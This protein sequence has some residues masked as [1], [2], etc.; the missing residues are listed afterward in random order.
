[1]NNITPF[2]ISQTFDLNA[3][4]LSQILFDQRH[5]PI[6]ATQVK[7]VGFVDPVFMDTGE[8]RDDIDGASVRTDAP[9]DSPAVDFVSQ[10]SHRN[11]FGNGEIPRKFA[12]RCGDAL[13]FAVKI[14]KKTVPTSIVKQALLERAKL[15]EKETGFAP[16]RAWRREQKEEVTKDL[17]PKCFPSSSLIISYLD[18]RNKFLVIGSS[19]I[20]A[21]EEILKMILK[22][23]PGLA[24]SYLKT[25]QNV[26]NLMSSWV[27][28]DAPDHF[29]VD[30]DGEMKKTGGGTIKVS[31]QDMTD[32]D[33]CKH[34]EVGYSVTKLA[35]T[36][37]DELSFVCNK[38][39]IFTGLDWLNSTSD[40]RAEDV[41][42]E[43]AAQMV[44][45]SG[46]IAKFLSD[47][48]AACGGSGTAV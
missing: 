5:A 15:F 41:E 48:V 2:D 10:D 3:E 46:T 4:G 8:A 19:S 37:N 17:L 11:K 22:V 43:F 6:M 25:A 30:Q 31:G 7:S 38:N 26:G 23:L 36:W 47:M 20:S 35:M 12:R 27:K 39:F 29:T 33:V 13:Y 45:E 44:M 1:M 34:L 40:T 32:K 21:S 9:A 24:P 42:S 16:G 28:I 18:L 14:E